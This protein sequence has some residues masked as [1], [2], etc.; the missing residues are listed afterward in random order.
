MI[1]NAITKLTLIQ[2]SVCFFILNDRGKYK[3]IEEYILYV[4]HAM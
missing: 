4:E 3:D 1:E 2:I